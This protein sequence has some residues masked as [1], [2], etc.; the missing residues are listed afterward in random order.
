MISNLN[1]HTPIW[2]PYTQMK[3]E[4]NPIC[5]VSGKDA[6]LYDDNGKEYIDA[7]SSWW[8][9]IHGHS[10]PYI[11]KKMHEQMKQLEHVLF[12]GFTHRPA[13]TLS[14]KLLSILP[15]N[16]KKIFFS[17]DG[18]TAVEVALKMALQ[19]WSNQNNK[20][21]KKIISLKNAYHGDTFGAMS[22]SARSSFTRPFNSHL[23]PVVY[24]DV[25]RKNNYH[26][27][28][29]QL[30]S[31]MKKGNFAAFIFEPLVQGAGGMIMYEGEYLD[32]MIEICK[33]NHVL[34]IA[35]EVMTGFFRLGRMFASDFLKE[36]PDIMCLSKGLTGGFV[37]MGITTTTNTIFECFFSENKNKMFFHGHSYTGNP[38]NCT[39][40]IAS[41]ELLQKK[42]VQKKIRSIEKNHCYFSDR[43]QKK[44]VIKETRIK[45]SIL[46]LEIKTNEKTSY[47]NKIRDKLYSFY[48]SNGVL[49]RPLGNIV[50]IMPPYCISDEQLNKVYSVIEDS[51]CMLE[52]E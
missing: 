51:I 33:S 4:K 12:A 15:K 47:F 28:F 26:R 39:A 7:I 1:D 38:I 48:I 49:L 42:S 27:V 31:L 14:K 17:D 34:T 19:Y 22:V 23:F 41:L 30:H 2:H 40:A 6:L 3:L 8:V 50:Y 45:G 43:I 32:R 37:P 44:A 13:L 20:K 46:A 36:K 52:N 10:H 35:D 18:S 25:P 29:D 24:L 16:Q 5:I 9:N 21:K 11:I